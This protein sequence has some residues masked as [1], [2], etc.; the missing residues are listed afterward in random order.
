MDG[1]EPV[2]LAELCRRIDDQEYGRRTVETYRT[3]L[4]TLRAAGTAAN[5]SGGMRAMLALTREATQHYRN[6]PNT[7]NRHW[8]GIGDWRC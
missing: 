1:S 6:V 8:D 5:A 3:D 4:D 7:V 2:A